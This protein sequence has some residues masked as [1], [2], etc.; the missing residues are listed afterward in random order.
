MP[1]RFWNSS[2]DYNPPDFKPFRRQG[3]P[4]DALYFGYLTRIKTK[5]GTINFVYLVDDMKRLWVS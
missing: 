5:Q 4:L 1:L 2:T 3:K